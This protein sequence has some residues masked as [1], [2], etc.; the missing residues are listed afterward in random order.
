VNKNGKLQ[1]ASELHY[2]AEALPHMMKRKGE[3]AAALLAGGGSWFSSSSRSVSLSFACRLTNGTCNLVG[4]LG[5][6]PLQLLAR[7]LMS[8]MHVLN[9]VTEYQ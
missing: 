2:F 5:D 4:L 1:Q 6:I 8:E 3:G 9:R 7:I